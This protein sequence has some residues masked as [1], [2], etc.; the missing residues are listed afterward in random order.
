MCK[1]RVLQQQG[2]VHE[3]FIATTCRKTELGISGVHEI[4]HCHKMQ[5]KS[6]KLAESTNYSLSQNAE[7]ESE[8]SGVHKFIGHNMQKESLKS[9][10]ELMDAHHHEHKIMQKESWKLA[11]V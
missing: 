5:N 1:K 8:I 9:A 3:S 4:I 11:E 2:R 6:L 10:T 7:Q